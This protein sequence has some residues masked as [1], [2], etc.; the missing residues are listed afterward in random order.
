MG[1]ERKKTE[2]EITSCGTVSRGMRIECDEFQK[3]EINS[4]A[5]ESSKRMS[6]G[7]K[8][9]VLTWGIQNI[10]VSA[11]KRSSLEEV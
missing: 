9:S 10:C 1:R 7:R 5:L 8:F 4:I 3:E 11:K 2:L 6:I